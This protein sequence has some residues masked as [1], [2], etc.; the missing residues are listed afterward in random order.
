MW[1]ISPIFMK[2]DWET[3]NNFGELHGSPARNLHSLYYIHN[4]MHC[5]SQHTL[6]NVKTHLQK[7]K[8]G[9]FQEECAMGCPVYPNAA[10]QSHSAD[11]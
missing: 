11:H 1:R 6:K 5:T 4:L 7:T 8:Q 10:E 2:A 3:F 9:T